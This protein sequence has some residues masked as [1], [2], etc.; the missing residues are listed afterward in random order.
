MNLQTASSTLF[1][2]RVILVF[3]VACKHENNVAQ[4]GE[5]LKLIE[6]VDGL[7]Q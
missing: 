2:I 7:K 1:S 3:R 6:E 5:L 4:E